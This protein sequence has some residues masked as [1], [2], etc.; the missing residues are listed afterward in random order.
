MKNSGMRGPFPHELLNCPMEQFEMSGCDFQGT[1]LPSNFGRWQNLFRL[2]IEGARNFSSTLPPQMSDLTSLRFLWLP[3]N[4]N[5]TG[6]LPAN[7]SAS[8][9]TSCLFI[10]PP[11]F[12]F[13]KV[14]RSSQS[15]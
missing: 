6:S 10:D 12:L 5:L 9:L 3:R 2:R 7:L 1:G 14:A 11:F 13:H 8:P 4:E 15:I